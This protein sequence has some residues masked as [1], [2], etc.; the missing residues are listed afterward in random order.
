[1]HAVTSL[2]TDGSKLMQPPPSASP[3]FT[4]TMSSVIADHPPAS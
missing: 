3:P 2:S 1:M 4:L